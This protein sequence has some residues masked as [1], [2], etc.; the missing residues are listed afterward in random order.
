M[1]AQRHCYVC[2]DQERCL[3]FRAVIFPMQEK[4]EN[5]VVKSRGL[6]CF[7]SPNVM[8]IESFAA[9]WFELS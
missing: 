5:L 3:E 1:Y 9:S 8:K 6:M 2:D 7:Q 4:V